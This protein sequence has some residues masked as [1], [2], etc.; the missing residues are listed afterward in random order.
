[1][2]LFGIRKKRL[3][4]A[5]T[6][7][8]RNYSPEALNNLGVINAALVLLPENP[9]NEFME[10]YSNIGVKNIAAEISVDSNKKIYNISGMTE[11]NENNIDYDAIYTV[12]GVSL[13]KN[14]NNDRPVNVMASG[15]L[16]YDKFTNI[17][18]INKS[19]ISVELDFEY[20]KS[21][22]F[23]K[24]A[25]LDK[26]FIE[27]IDDTVIVGGKDIYFD[28]DITEEVLFSK[29]IYF[30]AGKNIICNKQIKSAVQIKSTVG[31]KYVFNE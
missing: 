12:S 24:D 8:L 15:I 28:N 11:L 16:V 31:S 27:L 4:N 5:A 18:F 21:K 2:S 10:A 13:I 25:Y 1:M 22:N 29:N 30:V 19:G 26:H 14:L 20:T 17:N 23:Q 9:T 7:D 6:V 3:I